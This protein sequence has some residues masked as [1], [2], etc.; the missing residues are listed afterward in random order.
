MQALM[1]KKTAVSFFPPKLLELP[2][3]NI[4][5]SLPYTFKVPYKLPSTNVLKWHI[6]EKNGEVVINKSQKLETIREYAF[7]HTHFKKKTIKNSIK[8][9][10]LEKLNFSKL[11]KRNAKVSNSYPWWQMG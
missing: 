1:S 6:Q 4:L 8:T 11:N 10:A 7:L 9:Q 5:F 3:E 2:N